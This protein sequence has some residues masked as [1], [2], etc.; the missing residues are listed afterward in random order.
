MFNQEFP[1]REWGLL[2][3]PKG[4]EDM[5][6]ERGRDDAPGEEALRAKG[7]GQEWAF[8]HRR[9]WL[10]LASWERKARRMDWE[11]KLDR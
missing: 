7:R 1:W 10:V 9:Q 11:E 8:A 4:E 2:R 3:G 6:L 5:R